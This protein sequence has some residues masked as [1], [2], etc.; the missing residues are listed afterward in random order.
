MVEP[1][2]I[3]RLNNAIKEQKTAHADAAQKLPSVPNKTIRRQGF[4]RRIPS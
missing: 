1:P 4:R 3:E 2:T